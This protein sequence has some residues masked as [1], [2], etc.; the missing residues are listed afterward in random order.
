MANYVYSTLSADMS[1]T[2]WLPGADAGSLAAEGKTIFVQGGANVAQKAKNSTD[3]W[4]PLGRATEVSDEDL[5][6]LEQNSVFQLHKK[7]GF[8][9]VQKKKADVEKV[10]A[11]MMRGDK[12][13]P[14][15]ESDFPEETGLSVSTDVPRSTARPGI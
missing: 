8:I 11:D 13:R 9:T 14:L 6:L 1:Y 2:H 12:S 5:A 7:N 15:T 3:I 10:V 4:T